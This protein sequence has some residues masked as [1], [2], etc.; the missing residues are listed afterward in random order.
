MKPIAWIAGLLA[1]GLWSMA[2]AAG[3][4]TTGKTLY[5]TCA[6]CHGQ[7]GEGMPAL[8]APALAGQE[9]WYVARQLHLFKAG[10]RGADPKDTYGMQMRP[11]A[12]I[13]PTNQAVEDVAA[14]IQTFPPAQTNR[15]LEGEPETGKNRYL[16]CAT[17]HGQKGEGNLAYNAPA[18]AQQHDWYL[19]TQLKHFKAGIRGQSPK[20]TFGMQMQPVAA[21]LMDDQAMKDVIAYIKTLNQ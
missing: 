3:D 17:C 8:N 7:R 11:M 2:H 18:L 6:A 20:D 4:A 1:V 10:I 16:L 15:T 13:L 19:F 9:D 14:Y 21:T 5:G 12:M